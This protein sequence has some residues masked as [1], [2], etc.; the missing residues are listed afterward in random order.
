MWRMAPV[1]LYILFFS[2][3]VKPR[4]SKASCKKH[5]EWWCDNQHNLCKSFLCLE[6]DNFKN[7]LLHTSVILISST[8]SIPSTVRAPWLMKEYRAGSNSH[9][10]L[11]ANKCY[12]TKCFLAV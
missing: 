10:S 2:S 1:H 3:C 7:C 9:N 12:I 5:K 8:S 4:M 11:S 6:N